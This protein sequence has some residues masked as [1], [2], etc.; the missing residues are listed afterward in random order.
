[1]TQ[2]YSLANHVLKELYAALVKLLPHLQLQSFHTL[3]VFGTTSKMKKL[4]DSANGPVQLDSMPN[5]TQM[6]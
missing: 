5:Q 3:K 4:Q 1:M 2:L 6:Q